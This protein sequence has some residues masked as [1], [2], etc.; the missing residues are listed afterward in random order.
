MFGK[1][2]NVALSLH[3]LSRRGWRLTPGEEGCNEGSKKKFEKMV[4]KIW[5]EV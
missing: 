2:M 4:K 3:P 1:A 5:R